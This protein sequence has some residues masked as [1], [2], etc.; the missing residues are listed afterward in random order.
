MMSDLVELI[1]SS[2]PASCRWIK[3]TILAA[4][5]I[6]LVVGN[7]LAA[8]LKLDLFYPPGRLSSNGVDKAFPGFSIS[9][10]PLPLFKDTKVSYQFY[11]N[12]DKHSGMV[13][14]QEVYGNWDGVRM[15]LAMTAEDYRRLLLTA[16]WRDLWSDA[17]KK[18][19]AKSDSE[20]G[21]G[22]LR[23]DIPW[24]S[25]KLVKSIIGEGGA[26][27][28]VTGYR[29]ITI[30]GK[31]QWTD[32]ESVATQK[33]SKFPALNMEQIASFQISGTIG[34]KITVDVNQDSKRQQSLAN[35]ILLRYTGDEDDVVKTI[36]LGNTNL[37]LPS[38]RFIG[39]SQ[40][41][42]GL[43]G[44]KTTAQVGA[45]ELTAIASQE[46]S[47]NEGATFT[48]GSESSERI[49]R[50]WDYL[51]NRY[52]DLRARPSLYPP[53]TKLPTDI[54]AGDTIIKVELYLPTKEEYAYQC[55]LY[56]DPV[57]RD[58]YPDGVLVR[59][60]FGETEYEAQTHQQVQYYF[61]PTEHYVRIDRPTISANSYVG[62]YMEVVRGTDTLVIGEV[63][64][65]DTSS[66]K[67]LKMLKHENPKPSYITWNYVWRNVYQLGGAIDDLDNFD[68]KIYKGQAT[69]VNDRDESD[70]DYSPDGYYIQL[71]GL[72]ENP[73]DGRIDQS[74]QIIDQYYGHLFF[75]SRRPFVVDALKDDTVPEIYYQ[76]TS[77]IKQ[78]SS[79]FYMMVNSS[80]RQTEF[81]LGHFDIV[82]GSETVTLNGRRLTKDIDYRILYEIGK[83]QFLTDDALDPTANVQVDYEYAPLITSEKKTLLGVRGEYKRGRNFK[84]GTTVL[85][86][87]EK[88]TDRKPRLGEEQSR[89]LN[90]DTDISYSFESQ[91]LT[92]LMNKLPLIESSIPS[93][94]QFAGE[95][96]QSL[97]NPNVLGEA[98]LDDFEGSRERY[99]LGVTRGGWHVASR[100]ENSAQVDRSR[101]IWYNPYNQ[102]RVTDIYDREVRAGEDRTH[103]L[104]LRYTPS[105]SNATGTWGGVMKSFSAGV[106]DQTLTKFIELRLFGKKG[107]L[108][109]DLG[110]ISEDIDGDGWK[111]SE[112]LNANGILE[113]N[114]DTGLDSLFDAQEPGSGTDPAGDNWEYDSKDPN[115]YEKINGTEGN[116]LDP[117]TYGL[118]DTEDINR[119]GFL[120]E[121]N[122]YYSFRVNL[123]PDSNEFLVEGSENDNNWYTVR[124]PFQDEGVGDSIGTP[125]RGDIR[126]AR[127][128]LDGVDDG[129]TAFVTI[130]NIEMTRNLWEP[131]EVGSAYP[132]RDTVTYPAP[133]F[134]VAVVNTEENEDYE[135]PPGVEGFLD[136]TTGLREKEQSLA[137]EFKD[138]A[139]G[140]TG[141]AEKIPYRPE[142]LTGYRQLEMWVHGDSLRSDVQYFLR[143][144]TDA[145]N[146]YEYSS[147]I[148][149]GWDEEHSVK[150]VFDEM[151]PLKLEL[152]ELRLDDPTIGELS[153]P[154][155]RI[156]GKPSL[157]KIKYYALGVVNMDSTT[158][159]EPLDTT[160]IIDVNPV[161]LS[162]Y[163]NGDPVSGEVWF[164]EMRL[165]E[166]RKDRGVA[167]FVSGSISLGD[168]ASIS[169][170][171]ET[172]DAYFRKLTSADRGN[173]G[174]GR[175]TSTQGYS[176]TF[177]LDKVL[178]QGW[179]ASIP[180][181]YSWTKSVL[182]PRLVTGSDIVVPDD[183]LEEEKSKTTS[184]DFSVSES[185]RSDSK[186]PLFSALLNKLRTSF[187]FSKSESNTPTDPVIRS[188]R[189]T[190]Q[191]TYD[192]SSPR[193]TG[194]KVFSPFQYLFF[195]SGI[196]NSD[197]WPFPTRLGLSGNLNR[198]LDYRK[199]ASSDPT[200]RYV[201]TFKGRL[202][203]GVDP[204]PGIQMSYT[205]DTDRDLQDA[206]LLK[207]SLNPKEFKLGQER[208]FSES[209]STT[210]SP[211]VTSFITGTRL[212]FS[213]NHSENLDPKRQVQGTRRVDNSRSLSLAAS[214]NLEKVF[215]KNQPR[216][217]AA[218]TGDE[219]GPM[220]RKDAIPSLDS[221]RA[222]A[223]DSLAADS[224]LAESEE[225]KEP[226]VPGLPVW[227]Y[228][229][230]FVRFFTSRIDP[231]TGQYKTDK[232]ISQNGFVGRPSL[233]Y[234]LGLSEEPGVGVKAVS[235]SAAQIDA[236][237]KSRNY[238]LGSGVELPLGITAGIRWS[239]GIRE[240]SNRSTKDVSTT[241]PDL[242]FNFSRFFLLKFTDL[243]ASSF[244]LDSKYSRTEKKAV[245]IATDLP[246][247]KNISSSFSPLVSAKIA[248]KFAPAFSTTFKLDKSQSERQQFYTRGT[249]Q[250]NLQTSTV[251][252]SSGITINNGYTFRGGSKISLPLLGSIKIK[253]QMSVNLDLSRTTQTSEKHDPGRP[254]SEIDGKTDLTVQAR[255][256][257]SFSTNIKGG[258]T[259]RWRDS[260]SKKTNRTTHLR[261][262]GFWAEINF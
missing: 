11:A 257:Y 134:R 199:P 104:V 170:N 129:D 148:V 124:I 118:P 232:R 227:E 97:P 128:W 87:S 108:H 234:R 56:V 27:L 237:S 32:Q 194:L 239:Y 139:P 157:T 26:G 38:T 241:F 182:T 47:S 71:L 103:V 69:N 169:A 55:S 163:S 105:G 171:Y 221:L 80:T 54:V 228:P 246:E 91:G 79:K 1:R 122:N 120:D 142:D 179:R 119:S 36:E 72:D 258:M 15:P 115:N 18:S 135:P 156:V 253:T 49:I 126:Y 226:E 260:S 109:V 261:E 166:V 92:D 229:L 133:D 76:S 74:N 141:M 3:L 67:V 110:E 65:A 19:L 131:R 53:S 77:S 59:R 7:G 33:Q 6:I 94:V 197:F 187:S 247:S 231:I 201:R 138:F 243:F 51:D 63:N 136:K 98:F 22:L 202:S 123:D 117:D 162:S 111:D 215:G 20:R 93:R 44:V 29:K 185:F 48:A 153:D 121:A 262:L 159:E 193:R 225:E 154:P 192:L 204:F 132:L 242:S 220:R 174:S 177:Q 34:S 127:I 205:M 75:P 14:V 188:E 5:I 184:W 149:P 42:Q 224:L 212:S 178:P 165:T 9:V 143:V 82:D 195:P 4:T 95:I 240:E 217:A 66:Y 12:Y 39:Y 168:V 90:L 85:F 24:K 216:G 209:F 208:T 245:N 147:T 244:N 203:T 180:M 196:T 248:W 259:A 152:Q 206:E 137:I 112:D 175:E 70:L 88:T 17:A 200:T 219:R 40:S 214:L 183:R 173:L 161:T 37:S 16:Q 190:A 146:F 144:G 96:G 35:R 252:Y 114:E 13:V 41:V 58:E 130:A 145:Q 251:D 113:E 81:S 189:Y 230:R 107:V 28:K 151:T 150:M 30:S 102:Y 116:G 218:P 164:D 207:F 155:Y 84:M 250:G 21:G 45:L 236:K 223:A 68:L 62:V 50:D 106:F 222:A 52:F 101:L 191:A 60:C 46:K 160:K 198:T 210:W 25:P 255:A 213:S 172:K 73:K 181:R 167:A 2:G 43:F 78:D 8:G 256:S 100:P 158:I 140:D 186:N 99:S 61:H 31:S 64:R 211:R 176:L 233:L 254:V 23:I 125:D 86:K 83:I 249:E 238:S 235:G 57:S 89:F 10:K